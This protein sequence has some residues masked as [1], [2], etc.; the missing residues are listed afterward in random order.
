MAAVA[1]RREHGVP[2]ARAVFS[3]QK[4]GCFRHVTRV[5]LPDMKKLVLLVGIG[6]ASAC[7]SKADDAIA[8]LEGFKNKMCECK[9]KACVEG[10]EKEMMEWG[11]KM[12]DEVKEADASDAQK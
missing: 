5:R 12:K 11:A 8:A 7:G 6:F 3:T 9:D 4:L 2:T 10:V 1:R